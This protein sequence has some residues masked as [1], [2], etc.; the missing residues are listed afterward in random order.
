MSESKQA[1][2][3]LWGKRTSARMAGVFAL[4]RLRELCA[5][6]VAADDAKDEAR[7]Q[8]TIESMR[9][10]VASLDSFRRAQFRKWAKEREAQRS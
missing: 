9:A 10:V 6:F 2:L 4:P 7:M 5:E 8:D 1:I 3:P